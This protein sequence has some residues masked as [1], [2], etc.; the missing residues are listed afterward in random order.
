MLPQR[1]GID[2]SD[3]LQE[4]GVAIVRSLEELDERLAGPVDIFPADA[5]GEVPK[6]GIDALADLGIQGGLQ[7]IE[8]V[9]DRRGQMA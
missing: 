1:L 7:H 3:E 9:P 8:E 6:H 4:V 5:E 2:G